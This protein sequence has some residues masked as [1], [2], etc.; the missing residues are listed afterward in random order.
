MPDRARIVPAAI[1]ES[2]H[3]RHSPRAWGF[4]DSRFAVRGGMVRFE[5]ARY[6]G[7]GQDLPNFAPFVETAIGIPFSAED[8]NEP[9]E[10]RVPSGPDVTTLQERLTLVLGA[11]AV[12]IDPLLR[13][14]H[15]HGHHLEEIFHLLYGQV[16]RVPDVVVWP[17][18]DEEVALVL[19]VAREFEAVVIPFGGGTCVSLALT[20]PSPARLVISLDLGRMNQVRW[21]DPVTRTACI[22]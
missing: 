22:E 13:L 15:G 16:E 18:T 17:A 4:E 19:T 8:R 1:T 5:S 11:A 9:H 12:S 10:I 21:I 6:P 2:A 20:C 3:D 7:A 14:R